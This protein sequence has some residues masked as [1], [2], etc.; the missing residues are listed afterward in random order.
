MAVTVIR[1]NRDTAVYAA[2]ESISVTDTGHLRVSKSVGSSSKTL[3]IFAPSEWL[4]A[5]LDDSEK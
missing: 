1:S 3:A 4:R 5:Y 2:G